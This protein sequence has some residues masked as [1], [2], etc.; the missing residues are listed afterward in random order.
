MRFHSFTQMHACFPYIDNFTFQICGYGYATLQLCSLLFLNIKVTSPIFYTRVKM[1]QRIKNYPLE[2]SCLSA[3]FSEAVT[4]VWIAPQFSPHPIYVYIYIYIYIS[5]CID[6]CHEHLAGRKARITRTIVSFARLYLLR[7][8][9]SPI[10]PALAAVRA[11][12]PPSFLLFFHFFF[13]PVCFLKNRRK[14]CTPRYRFRAK[15]HSR[16]TFLLSQHSV[17]LRP[18]QMKLI[19]KNFPNA[20]T[21]LLLS[22]LY[23]YELLSIPCQISK[24]KQKKKNT[25]TFK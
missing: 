19:S 9:D 23:S 15:Y 10:I 17:N 21:N 16:L 6:Q 4:T 12:L 8:L 22:R 25:H 14:C 24:E 1:L 20:E 13:Y 3:S 2:R 5:W 18:T 11:P 7:Q